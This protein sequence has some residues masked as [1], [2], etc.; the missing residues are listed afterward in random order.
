M[1]DLKSLINQM[2]PSGVPKMS[3]GS[4]IKRIR[5]RG[6][7]QPD[8]EQVYVVS[9]I[10]GMVRAEEYRE[11]TIHSEDT[12]NYTVISPGMFA[13]NPSRLNIG[14]IAML[15]DNEPG[16]VSPMYVVFGINEDLILGEYMDLCLK[17]NYVR[18]KI[19]SLKEEG[20]R[21]RFDFQRW[22]MIYVSVPPIP[23]QEEIVRA[24]SC[25]SDAITTL[26]LELSL[27][28]KQYCYYRD[29]LLQNTTAEKVCVVDVCDDIFLG[30]T[31]KV[32]YV[33]EDGI[34]LVRATNMTSGKLYFNDVKYISYD[35]HRKL[36]KIHK[37]R[38]G[39]VLVSKSGTL[40]A[41]CI[42]DTDREFSIY[43]SLIC[44]HPNKTIYN[45]YLMHLLRSSKV[46]D[47]MLE[48]KVGNEIKHLNLQTFRKLFV[49]LPTMKEQIEISNIL[50]EFEELC[51]DLERGLPAEINLRKRQY[52]YYR[53]RLLT[54]N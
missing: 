2:C 48:K 43:E 39:D 51:C 45:R 36:T 15:R 18:N 37:A 52:D 54:I 50:D 34:P 19:E 31:N 32:D 30:L 17:S 12:S 16:L 20:A 6:K 23:V 29:Y 4:V 13:Y 28:E 22:D 25:F 42:V 47:E 40:G 21:F 24:L 3:I 26:E 7:E 41:V 33:N 35:Q 10:Q 9:N 8:V 53:D 44:L 1:E 14:S 38:K 49:P 27:R 11:N 46:Q 5:T